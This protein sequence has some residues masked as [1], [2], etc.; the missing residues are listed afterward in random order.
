[1]RNDHVCVPMLGKGWISDDTL[2]QATPLTLND[3]KDRESMVGRQQGL[4]MLYRRR[5]VTSKITQDIA[6]AKTSFV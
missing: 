5:H 3:G 1:M 4:G 6:T 2:V